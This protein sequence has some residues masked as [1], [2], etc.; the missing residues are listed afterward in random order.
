MV[1][2]IFF[3]KKLLATFTAA[4]LA[5]HAYAAESREPHLTAA[6]HLELKEAGDFSANERGEMIWFSHIGE[7]GSHQLFYSSASLNGKAINL[8]EEISD[9]L[10]QMGYKP[11]SW[12]VIG[13]CT[14]WECNHFLDY[15][16][17]FAHHSDQRSG[18]FID[19]DGN[20]LVRFTHE[21]LTNPN[22]D[23]ANG[24]E[25]LYKIAVWN[26]D[27]GF[28]IIELPEIDTIYDTVK[29]GNYLFASGFSSDYNKWQIA[30]LPMPNGYWGE[31]HQK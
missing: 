25:W 11:K 2:T 3:F 22:Y 16:L 7:D 28:K 6:C 21:G 19:A 26:K 24:E 13:E 31:R 1:K 27:F 9:V 30:V 23:G 5:N 18:K 15:D 8:T 10:S 20:V 12:N 29:K 17:R 14:P 4:I